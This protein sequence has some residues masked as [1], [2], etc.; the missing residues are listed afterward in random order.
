M[1]CHEMV[2]VAWPFLQFHYWWDSTRLQVA[3]AIADLIVFWL[4][5]P[6]LPTYLPNYIDLSII[7]P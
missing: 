3:P 1:S 5:W 7:Q 4:S 2:V 6:A